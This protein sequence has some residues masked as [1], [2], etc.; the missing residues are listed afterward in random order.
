MD[1]RDRSYYR[2]LLTSEI[3]DDMARTH[4][5]IVNGYFHSIFRSFDCKRIMD[6]GC[7]LGYF[8]DN[9]GQGVEAIGVDSNKYAVEHCRRKGIN[10]VLG[11]AA[12]LRAESG[13]LDGVI[14]SHLLEHIAE[15]GKVFG[16]FSRILKKGGVLIVRVPF[17]DASFYDDWTHIRPYTKKTLERLASAYGLKPVRIFYYHYD[18]PFKKWGDSVFRLVNFIRHLPVFKQLIDV[19]IKMYGLPPKELVMVASK[20]AEK[21]GG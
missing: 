19:S 5:E 11:D 8:L 20:T 4:R 3:S 7:G 12:D 10:A 18:L 6:V 1:D 15:P 13:S 2:Y 16:E 21:S 9:A 17:F 14:C